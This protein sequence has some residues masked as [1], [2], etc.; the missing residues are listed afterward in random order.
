MKYLLLIVSLMFF[1]CSNERVKFQSSKWL[2]VESGLYGENYRKK[3]VW[4]LVH[5]KLSFGSQEEKGTFKEEV[6][7]LIGEPD[8]IDK[9]DFSEMYDIEEKYGFIDPNGYTVLKLS[10]I[11]GFLVFWKIEESTFRE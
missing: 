11:K 1:S 10:Y 8:R 9:C 3:M 4:D 7:K 2:P 6:V 5:N